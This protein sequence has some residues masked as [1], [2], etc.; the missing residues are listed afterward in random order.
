MNAMQTALSKLAVTEYSNPVND[1]VRLLNT[2]FDELPADSVN[3]TPRLKISKS[4]VLKVKN[5]LPIPLICPHC[6]SNVELVD[7]IKIYR[8]KS[9]GAWPYAYLCMGKDCRSYVGLHPYTTIPLG[10][11]ATATMRDA[12][13]KAKAV[14]EPLWRDG[15]MSRTKAYSWLATQLGIKDHNDCHIG[16]FDVMMCK[17]VIE[18]CER[19]NG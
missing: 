15:N 3:D 19:Y 13:K 12:R 17:Q 9:Y 4:S 10:T 2:R 16:Y 8:T 18:V 5:P 11:L 6:A 1:A 7:N 14:F